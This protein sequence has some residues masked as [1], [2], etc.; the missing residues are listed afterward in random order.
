MS[1]LQTSWYSERKN[2]SSSSSSWMKIIIIFI[3]L[4]IILIIHTIILMMINSANPMS[5]R[6]LLAN[7][8]LIFLSI[9][10]KND[11]SSN[12]DNVLISLT[13]SLKTFIQCTCQLNR[14]ETD[15]QQN[16][17]LTKFGKDKTLTHHRCQQ[18]TSWPMQKYKQADPQAL[19]RSGP[20]KILWNLSGEI[21]SQFLADFFNICAKIGILNR[22]AMFRCFCGE[23]LS[24]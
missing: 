11:I 20:K 3:S 5:A 21:C 12:K 10:I 17:D 8:N 13:H 6:H 14:W 2:V 7:V 18:G 24:P 19:Q 23:G 9:R 4:I 1:P 15:Y 22:T 16:I